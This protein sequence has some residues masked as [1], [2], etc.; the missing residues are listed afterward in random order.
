VPSVR[1][2]FS[3]NPILPLAAHLTLKN[4]SNCPLKPDATNIT[5]RT[6]VF[7]I[8]PKSPNPKIAFV[9]TYIPKTEKL[10]R[11]GI[12]LIRYTHLI[13]T[14]DEA[15][16]EVFDAGTGTSNP[17]CKCGKRARILT[18]FTLRN[19]GKRFYTCG[20]YVVR[21]FF[22]FAILSRNPAFYLTWVFVFFAIFLATQCVI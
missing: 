13:P 20:T 4:T 9:H 12:L 8:D 19:F 10:L 11:A 3:E 18:T 6:H 15:Y 14:M 21:F 5:P 22:F 17:M 1:D 16:S 7:V 2:L